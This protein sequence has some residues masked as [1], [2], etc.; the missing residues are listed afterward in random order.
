MK[1]NTRKFLLVY[2]PMFVTN[3]IS[4]INLTTLFRSTGV[5]SNEATAYASFP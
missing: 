2:G 3:Y 5:F 4:L 1:L